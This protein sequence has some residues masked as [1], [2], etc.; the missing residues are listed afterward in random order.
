VSALLF[1]HAAVDDDARSAAML[2]DRERGDD[3]VGHPA[4]LLEGRHLAH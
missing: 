1:Q 4:I 3:D 2:A